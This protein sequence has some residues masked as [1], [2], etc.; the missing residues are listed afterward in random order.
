MKAIFCSA[1]LSYRVVLF[2]GKETQS[3]RHMEALVLLVAMGMSSEPASTWLWVPGFGLLPSA[4]PL[5]LWVLLV[6][7][8]G[9]PPSPVGLH[10]AS[11]TAFFH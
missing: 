5:L 4:P 9:T 2:F 8:L 1:V 3:G 10:Q 6:A 11:L 7:L